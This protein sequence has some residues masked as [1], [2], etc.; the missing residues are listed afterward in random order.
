MN[1][2]FK[3]I[4]ASLLF[5]CG[6]LAHAAPLTIAVAANVKYAFDDLAIEFK[7]E[8]GI[9]V[10]AVFSS[11][12]KITSQVK[13]GAPFDV[14]LS[15]DTEFPEL[16]YKEGLAVTQPKVYA[17]GVLVLWTKKDLDLSKGLALLTDAKIQKIA[18]ANPKLAPYGRAALQALESAKLNP[19]WCTVKALPIQHSLSIRVRLTLVLS[20][21]LWS[22][23]L[24]YRVK[25]N[26]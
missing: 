25:A 23:P 19:S 5:L 15:A 14:F 10:Q 18:I 21:S 17:Y 4:I 8:T 20:P 2:L 24:N 26:G 1:K 11:A 6:A 3:L 9:E 13:S 22:S 12:G 7:K 16:L